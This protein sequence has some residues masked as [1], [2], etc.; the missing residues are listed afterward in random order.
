MAATRI[1]KGG[2]PLWH[3]ALFSDLEAAGQEQNIEEIFQHLK[4]STR[5]ISSAR[6]NKSDSGGMGVPCCNTV[7]WQRYCRRVT[8]KVCAC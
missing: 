7:V 4:K 2:V 1:N 5:K 6:K 8:F 3:A